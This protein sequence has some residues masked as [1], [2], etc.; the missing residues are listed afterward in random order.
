MRFL[1]SENELNPSLVFG[2]AIQKVYVDIH[3]YPVG[4]MLSRY[5]RGVNG[6]NGAINDAHIGRK[7]KYSF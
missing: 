2:P 4:K 3:T 7:T 5:K 6:L 1:S